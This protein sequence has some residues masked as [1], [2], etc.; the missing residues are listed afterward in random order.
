MLLCLWNLIK[1]KKMFKNLISNLP[2]SPSLAGQLG[3]YI[4]RL[5]QEETTRRAGLVVTALAL[6]LQGLIVFA[7]T[8]TQAAASNNDIVYG[9]FTSKAD[10]LRIYDKGKDSAGRNDIQKIYSYFGVTRVDIQGTYIG[11]IN[12]KDFSGG[13]YSTGRYAYNKKGADEQAKLITGTDTTIYMRKLRSFDAG[14]QLDTGNGYAALIGKRSIDGKWFAIVLACGNVDFTSLPPAPKKPIPPT[15]TK[16]KTPVTTPIPTPT[17][18]VM[19]PV[20]PVLCPVNSDILKSSSECQVCTTNTS[21]WYMDSKCN[22]PPNFIT[23][24]SVANLTTSVRDANGTT[25]NSGD[26]LEYTLVVTNNGVGSGNYVVKDTISDVME[27][28]SLVD[29]GGATVQ[30]LSG[31]ASI[32]T[33]PDTITWPSVSLAPGQSAT[34]KFVVQIK[35]TLPATATNPSNPESYNCKI[36]N[37]FGQTT[38]VMINCP[39]PK[40]IETVTSSLPSTGPTENLLVGG[41]AFAVVAYFYARSRQLGREVHLI[42]RDANAGTI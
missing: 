10:L 28:A 19:T 42:R 9:G 39:V 34:K 41:I 14:H 20:A 22:V 8:E 2:F 24:K 38:N 31:D 18:P 36:T 35:D 30:S 32:N 27:Y 23:S 3:F 13:I 25:A 4:K 5:R 17:P 29:N 16:P 7:P 12:S 33:A 1:N 40:T 37:S 11:R 21:L 15:P 26:R 6:G